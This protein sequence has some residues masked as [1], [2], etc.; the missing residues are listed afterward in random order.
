MQ[1]VY[2]LPA[3]AHGFLQASFDLFLG[4]EGKFLAYRTSETSYPRSSELLETDLRDLG[5]GK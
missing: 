5:K 4:T 1:F 3:F 2:G